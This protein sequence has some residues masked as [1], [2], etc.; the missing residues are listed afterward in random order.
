M[1]VL[2]HTAT[3]IGI[4]EDVV[5]VERSSNKGLLVGSGYFSTSRAFTERTDRPEAL[6]NGANVDVETNFVVLKR[7]KRKGKTR[8][9]A[10]P[11][12]KGNVECGF[13]KCAS[14]SADSLG[15][16]CGRASGAVCVRSLFI[17]T[18]RPPRKQ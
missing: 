1:R 6:L 18:A 17:I 4:K 7:N 2:C 11:E 14:R 8:V 12:L 3:L 16:T 10:E 5:N 9:A 13:R 15:D